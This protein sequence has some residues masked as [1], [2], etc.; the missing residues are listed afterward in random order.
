MRDR[1]WKEIGP[2]LGSE[3]QFRNAHKT[4]RA[5]LVLASVALLAA[6]AHVTNKKSTNKNLFSDRGHPGCLPPQVT[7]VPKKPLA[8]V[9]WANGC[10]LPLLNTA[11]GGLRV[12]ANVVEQMFYKIQ[13]LLLQQEQKSK[14]QQQAALAAVVA[15]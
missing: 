9:H 14:M 3:S 10:Q 4:K 13:R 15:T 5:T 12:V 7:R 11:R 2:A 1:S 6:V 8:A